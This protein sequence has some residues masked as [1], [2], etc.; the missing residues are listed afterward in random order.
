MYLIM[1]INDCFV[2]LL[3]SCLRDVS[4]MLFFFFVSF[5]VFFKSNSLMILIV[6]WRSFLF[7]NCVLINVCNF[8]FVCSVKIVGVVK[9]LFVK[10]WFWGLFNCFFD[11]VK[12]KILF[13]IWNV[14][15][16]CLSYSYMLILID[17]VILLNIVVDLYDVV[18]KDVVLLWF[19][20]RYLF[21]VKL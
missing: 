17:L 6:F 11:C 20:L 18:I 9:F 15:S 12:F 16:R 8:G 21:R 4:V 3:G 13:M 14:N 19:F 1:F 2:L 7:L 5:W 10:F